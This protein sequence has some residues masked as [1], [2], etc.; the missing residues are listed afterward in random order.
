M[1]IIDAPVCLDAFFECDY[2]LATSGNTH[3]NEEDVDDDDASAAM[4]YIAASICVTADQLLHLSVSSSGPP[5]ASVVSLALRL[6]LSKHFVCEVSACSNASPH[7]H[8]ISAAAKPA[9]RVVQAAVSSYFVAG[10]SGSD[11]LLKPLLC[12]RDKLRP[13]A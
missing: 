2:I 3:Q 6:A 9:F 13:L 12:A 10:Q 4:W 7:S 11:D 1:R 8:Y 5:P